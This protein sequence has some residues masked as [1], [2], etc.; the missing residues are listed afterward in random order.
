M[1]TKD[2]K[3]QVGTAGEATKKDDVSWMTKQQ[4][5][6]KC[7]ELATRLDVT[8]NE[9]TKVSTLLREMDEGHTGSWYTLGLDAS[10]KQLIHVQSPNSAVVHT[11]RIAAVG[12]GLG[13]LGYLGYKAIK[14]RFLT[15]KVS[16]AMGEVALDQMASAGMAA[17][18]VAGFV[19]ATVLGA[20][21]LGGAICSS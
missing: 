7:D 1:D 21:S 8:Q 13:Y 2:T 16:E 10:I 3:I 11:A 17:V 5:E 20:A 14:N 4:L 15:K 6:E 19:G 9:K 18:P 12:G